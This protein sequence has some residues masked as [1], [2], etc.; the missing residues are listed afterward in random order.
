M[1]NESFIR[2]LRV[3][4]EKLLEHL[5]FAEAQFCART[6]QLLQEPLHCRP[7]RPAFLPCQHFSLVIGSKNQPESIRIK[8]ELEHQQFSSFPHFI[9]WAT[10][11]AVGFPIWID[12]HMHDLP[13]MESSY[14][15]LVHQR[16]VTVD[17]VELVLHDNLRQ[18][19]VEELSGEQRHEI[20]K[21]GSDVSRSFKVKP[22]ILILN[23]ITHT[24]D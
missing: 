2:Y 16:L 15:L 19:V 13:D 17:A 21:G 6:Q 9:L 10:R 8:P 20:L 3:R 24:C 22:Y 4:E 5:V 7:C 12:T 1:V 18:A 14:Q 11:R 23:K